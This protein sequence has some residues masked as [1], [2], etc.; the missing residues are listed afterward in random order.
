MGRSERDRPATAQVGT[1][2][3]SAAPAV[4]AAGSASTAPS[5]YAVLK[6]RVA[7]A[8]L[9]DRQPG[10]YLL[11]MLRNL[12]LLA[13]C[14]AVLALFRNP[15]IQAGDAILLGLVSG[16][17]GFQLHDA[18]HHQMFDHRWKN[19]LVA[20]LT[21]DVLLGM[22]YGWW[23]R[24]HN[25]HHANPNHQDLDPDI[26]SPAISYSRAQAMARRGLMRLVAR[27]QA[28]L[29]FPLICTLAWAMHG[30][31]AKFLASGGSRHRWLEVA[32]LLVHT[33]L[34]VGL[35]VHFLGPWSA[36]LVLLL[37]K[38]A[39]GF[40]LATVFAPN[41]KGMLQVDQDSRLD[42]LRRQ[43]L[44]SRNIRPRLLTDFWYGALNYQVEHH[45]FPTM[46]RNQMPRAHELV[47][48]Y[49]RQVGVSYHET[50]L[51]RSY[52]ELLGFLHE[53]GEPLRRRRHLATD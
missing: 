50:S 32:T 33:V 21:A 26:N 46:A 31:S 1:E 6:R 47:R 24:K 41:H 39:G 28:F 27:Y 34:V 8:G 37:W 22:S 35:L 18:G 48:Q 16:Q 4:P 51:F 40:Y 49:C 15:W 12:A 17:L 53:V 43:V 23:V 13:G 29:F 7:Q 19:T 36:L 5:D 30:A 25:K 44:T 11:L 14:C 9:L 45:L 38:G 10:Y 2:I 20:F 52:G 42:F 3:A